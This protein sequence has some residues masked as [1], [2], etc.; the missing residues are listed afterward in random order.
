MLG[1]QPDAMCGEV[2]IRPILPAK[3]Q[4]ASIEHV[5]VLDGEISVRIVRTGEGTKTQVTGTPGLQVRIIENNNE[6][7]LRLE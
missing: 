7:V 5:R 1:I 2:V 6:S 3:W 4:E